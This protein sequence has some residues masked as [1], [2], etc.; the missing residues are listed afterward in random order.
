MRYR[1]FILLSILF[2]SLSGFDQY[3]SHLIYAK[4]YEVVG[5]HAINLTNDT[6]KAKMWFIISEA[7]THDEF[8]QTTILAA[9]ELHKKYREYDLIQVILVPDKDMVATDTYYSSVYYAV[10]KKGLKGVSGADQKTMVSFE[11]LVRAAEKSLNKQE[12]EIAKLWHRHQADFPS[13]D[14]L[15]SLSYNEKKLVNF[16]ADSLK[17]DND[18]VN[19]PRIQ[20]LE[21]QGLDFLD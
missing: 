19:L 15:S 18:A 1:S 12:L 5:E 16:I 2:L 9:I 4:T 13:E 6:R 14:L 11:W 3:K 10:D 7:K 20:L 17:L 21:Y 8:A